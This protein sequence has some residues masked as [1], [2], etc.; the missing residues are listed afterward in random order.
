MPRRAG[1]IFWPRF[2][3][4]LQRKSKPDEAGACRASQSSVARDHPAADV[5]AGGCG[6]AATERVIP[7]HSRATCLT[8]LRDHAVRLMK[9]RGRHG[10]RRRCDGQ[11]KCNSDQPDHCFLHTVPRGERRPTASAAGTSQRVPSRARREGKTGA[12]RPH[13]RLDGGTTDM[14][15][16][17]EIRLM[18][19]PTKNWSKLLTHRSVVVGTHCDAGGLVQNH[20]Q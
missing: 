7:A 3:N 6:R 5:A 20:V 4:E 13:L 19:S 11:R 2:T 14:R 18:G 16:G 10:L 9:R 8:D 1:H 15:C 17:R 12:N